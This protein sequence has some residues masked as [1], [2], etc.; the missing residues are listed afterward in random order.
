MLTM[1]LSSL[2]QSLPGI[3]VTSRRTAPQHREMS[4][5]P[6]NNIVSVRTIG[7]RDLSQFKII[8]FVASILAGAVIAA[9][10]RLPTPRH[11]QPPSPTTGLPRQALQPVRKVAHP[12]WPRPQP[13]RRDARTSCRGHR[14]RTPSLLG[15][16]GSEPLAETQGGGPKLA[17]IGAACV[18]AR[19]DAEPRG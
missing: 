7:T 9:S 16:A 4:H 19:H 17:P 1:P 14:R 6:S 15:A 8:A 10:M 11:S 2:R 5:Q 3:R 18:D 12:R 13:A